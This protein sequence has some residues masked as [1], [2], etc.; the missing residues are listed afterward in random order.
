Q[1]VNSFEEAF[2]FHRFQLR[3]GTSYYQIFEMLWFKE[4][5]MSRCI[6]EFKRFVE[7]QKERFLE[8]ILEHISFLSPQTFGSFSLNPWMI[9]MERVPRILYLKNQYL[10]Y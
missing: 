5:I 2:E 10:G 3:R 7:E 8:E 1:R 4:E 6:S 9:Q